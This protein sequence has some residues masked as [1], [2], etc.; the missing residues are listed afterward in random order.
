MIDIIAFLIVLIAVNSLNAL[1]VP[2]TG[3]DLARELQQF[4]DLI[5]I[6]ELLEISKAYLAQDEHFQTAMKLMNSNESK[7]W[8]QDLEQAPEFKVLLNY[9]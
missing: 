4:V 7:Q 1:Q 3:L 9:T 2:F 5:P 8:V 6:E